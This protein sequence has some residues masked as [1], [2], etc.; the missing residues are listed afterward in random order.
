MILSSRTLWPEVN[1]LYGHGYEVISLAT[2]GNTI[3]SASKSLTEEASKI[4]IWDKSTYK[5]IQQLS[6]HLYTVVQLSFS[7]SGTYLASVSKDRSLA[8][9]KKSE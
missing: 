5:I 3:A 9:F 6:A 1:K 2:H 4:L 8:L 7:I